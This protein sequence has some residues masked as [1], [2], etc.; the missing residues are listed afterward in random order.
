MLQLTSSYSKPTIG[1][2]YSH[3]PLFQ[4]LST[5][6]SH[7]PCTFPTSG[8]FKHSFLPAD[9]QAVE[10]GKPCICTVGCQVNLCSQVQLSPCCSSTICCFYSHA[11]SFFHSS[12]Q[13]FENCI[14]LLKSL[15]T[16]KILPPTSQK[17]RRKKRKNPSGRTLTLPPPTIHLKCIK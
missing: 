7:L 13:L 12:Q 6:W 2:N 16:Q 14:C 4:P 15:R 17:K 9:T 3:G 5:L 8:Q 10:K 1:I 11:R